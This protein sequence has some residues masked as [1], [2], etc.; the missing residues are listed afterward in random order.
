M[1]AYYVP[2]TCRESGPD[3]RPT[4]MVIPT[5]SIRRGL[6]RDYDETY[7]IKP[8]LIILINQSIPNGNGA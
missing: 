6:C 5:R 3:D 4:L 8:K 1:K 2:A 7:V